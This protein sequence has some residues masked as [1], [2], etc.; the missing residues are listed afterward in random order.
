VI[1]LRVAGGYVVE[2]APEFEITTLERLLTVLERR[3][4]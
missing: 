1:R 3:A 4:G 2:V